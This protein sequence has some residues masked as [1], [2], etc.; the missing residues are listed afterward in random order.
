MDIPESAIAC[1]SARMEEI[2]KTVMAV[3]LLLVSTS[4]LA[5]KPDCF[6]NPDFPACRNNPSG[7]AGVNIANVP[8]P[9]TVT[10]LGLGMAALAVARRRKS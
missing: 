9:G 6:Q 10:L 2:M 3:L 4:L 8:E 7:L 1:R 5:G